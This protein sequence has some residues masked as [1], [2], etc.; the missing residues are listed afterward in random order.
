MPIVHSAAGQALLRVRVS[1]TP[2]NVEGLQE[3]VPA[4]GAP[5]LP[6]LA[7]D[8]LE[9]ERRMVAPAEFSTC[10]T[11][12][13]QLIEGGDPVCDGNVLPDFTPERHAGLGLD[14]LYDTTTAELFESEL[15]PAIKTYIIDGDQL[16]DAEALNMIGYPAHLQH[17]DGTPDLALMKVAGTRVRMILS[18]AAAV[19][20]A[21]SSRSRFESMHRT[22]SGSKHSGS[23]G[24]GSL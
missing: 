7:N 15:A 24:K 3:P 4:G 17:D 20:G 23:G 19:L 16:S 14:S 2:T 6:T 8:G 18:S 1:H 10:F 11:K 21:W 9:A 22:R 12:T 13:V 5:L